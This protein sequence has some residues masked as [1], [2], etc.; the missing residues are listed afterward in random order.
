MIDRDVIRRTLTLHEAKRSKPYKCSA[1]KWTIGVGRN[2]QDARFTAEERAYL[3]IPAAPL[4]DQ[5]AWLKLHPLSD[6]QITWLLDKTIAQTLKDMARSPRIAEAFAACNDV[7]GL[8]L[9]D[10]AY[11]MGV[12]GLNKFQYTLGQVAKG[13][14]NAAA[15]G[16]QDSK[17]YAQVG[18]RSVRLV[19]MMRSGKL[20]AELQGA[21]T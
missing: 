3:G 12:P 19:A 17:W 1:G 4:S 9:I 2:F 21:S 13:N 20:P 8:V 11:N 14:W 7:R 18:T 6:D 16:M 5:V 10:M 15:D